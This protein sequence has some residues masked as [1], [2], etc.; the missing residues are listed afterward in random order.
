MPLTI[1]VCVDSLGIIRRRFCQNRPYKYDF[2]GRALLQYRLLLGRVADWS[3]ISLGVSWGYLGLASF[4]GL[5]V[6][7][8]KGF[9]SDLSYCLRLLDITAGS[10]WY[11]AYLETV[12]G[13]DCLVYYS[14]VRRRL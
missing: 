1:I 10:K 6:F 9:H 8:Q 4:S 7:W 2:S 3:K 5:A 14:Y 11:R 12:E 13:G